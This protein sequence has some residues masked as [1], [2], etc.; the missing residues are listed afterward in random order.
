MVQRHDISTFSAVELKVVAGRLDIYLISNS[1][2][3]LP[4]LVLK[5]GLMFVSSF[6]FQIGIMLSDLQQLFSISHRL[7]IGE[8][9]ENLK[10]SLLSS[11][12]RSCRVSLVSLSQWSY[13]Y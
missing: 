10:S 3:L 4:S 9:K 12:R 6:R 13:R 2:H 5:K 11:L 7:V 1:N 8:A